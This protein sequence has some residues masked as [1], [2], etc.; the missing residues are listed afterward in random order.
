MQ[1]AF[2]VFFVQD[3]GS[4][5]M[6][7]WATFVGLYFD[8]P[9]ISFPEYAGRAVRSIH[10]VVELENKVPIQIVESLFFITHF[11]T[12]GKMDQQK[13]VER[14]RLTTAMGKRPYD[15]EPNKGV[16]DLRPRLSEKRYDHEFRWNPTAR[17]N[18]QFLKQIEA[19]LGI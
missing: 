4:L 12:R 9:S 18:A 8:F 6:I 1:I 10:T 19:I 2:R 17:E 7:P 3:D 5:R 14:Q 11:D 13:K 15:E 16:I